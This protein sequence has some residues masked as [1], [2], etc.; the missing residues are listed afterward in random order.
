VDLNRLTQKS[1]EAPHDA[2]TEA[3]RFGHTEI[4]AEHL[5]LALIEQP[6]GQVPRLLTATCVDPDKPR[7]QVAAELDRRPRAGAAPASARRD[8]VDEVLRSEG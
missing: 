1:Q 8:G 3:L 4:D 5:L 2:Q 6:G 7:E